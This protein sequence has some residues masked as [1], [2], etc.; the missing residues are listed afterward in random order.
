MAVDNFAI[1][2]R[3]EVLVSG[4][5]LALPGLLIGGKGSES[6]AD[7]QASCSKGS[8]RQIKERLLW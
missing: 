2:C 7:S 3:I 4:R 6:K 8:E 5:H 1:G